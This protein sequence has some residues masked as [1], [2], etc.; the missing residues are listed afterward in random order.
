[1]TRAV[2]FRRFTFGFPT[3]AYAIAIIFLPSSIF[4]INYILH[5]AC[6]FGNWLM[7][8]AISRIDSADGLRR[9]SG[10]I[11]GEL[12]PEIDPL[13]SPLPSVLS[14][15]AKRNNTRRSSVKTP[16]PVRE[17][18]PAAHRAAGGGLQVSFADKL[19]LSFQVPF[20]LSGDADTEHWTDG[21]AP[22]RVTVWLWRFPI[23]YVIG[24]GPL[25]T[26]ILTLPICLD[27]RR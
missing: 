5:C 9:R 3:I 18:A 24:T 16:V 20:F 10:W 26:K 8:R 4:F 6:R 17:V 22:G 19:P 27:T 13:R 14:G 21:P 7:P 23:P 11:I 2:S 12:A 1:M 15:S 25:R